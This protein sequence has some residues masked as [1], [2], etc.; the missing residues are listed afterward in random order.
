MLTVGD[1]IAQGYTRQHA[2]AYLAPRTMPPAPVKAAEIPPGSA[3]L[4]A[5]AKANG[6]PC[7]DRGRVPD[8]VLTAWLVR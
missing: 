7:P 3:T 5:W 1:M 8:R 4:R 6:V 2:E